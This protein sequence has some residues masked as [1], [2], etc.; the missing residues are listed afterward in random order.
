MQRWHVQSGRG[1][2]RLQACSEEQ[3]G[4]RLAGGCGVNDAGIGN[5]HGGGTRR[6]RMR[7][8]RCGLRLRGVATASALI[9]STFSYNLYFVVKTDPI[10]CRLVSSS[11]PIL[12]Q[13]LP[14]VHRDFSPGELAAILQHGFVVQESHKFCNDYTWSVLLLHSVSS[15]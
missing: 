12:L 2:R 8:R 14:S 3:P 10:P 13:R 11:P 4:G 6:S 1:L 7:R 5:C 15:I 9:I